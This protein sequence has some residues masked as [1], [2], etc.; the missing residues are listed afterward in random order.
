MI[1]INFL[2]YDLLMKVVIIVCTYNE[3]ENTQNMLPVLDKVIK[4]I[5]AHQVQ[6]LYVDDSS[7]DNTA[8]VIKKGMSEYP[9]LRLLDG[10]KKQG[11]GMAYS[12]GMQYAMKEMA[13]DYLLEF[14]ADFQHPPQDIPRLIAE[15]DRGFDYIVGSRYIPGGSVPK[16]WSADRKMIS[17]FGNLTAR[18]LLIMPKIHDITGGFKLS[19]VKGFMDKF[20]FNKLLSRQFAYKI[21]LFAYMVNAGARVKEVPF[22]FASRTAGDSKIL[23]NEMKETLRVIFKYQ[24]Q[25]PKILRFLKFGIVGGTGLFIQTTFFEIF[26]VFSHTL[27]PSV[28]TT[29]G[30]EMAIISN[31]IL[32]NMWTFNEYKVTGI[33]MI[34]KFVQ[35]NLTSLIALTIQFV[36]L[37][38]GESVSKGNPFVIQLFYFGAIFLVLITNYYIYNKFIWKTKTKAN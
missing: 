3:K 31:F 29:I 16:E 25:N 7:P 24:L 11:L 35:F 17:F 8:D 9:W 32:N 4:S 22:N 10:G 23:K 14:D 28:A 37:K 19:R 21:H 5:T 13:A 20:D 12:R 18:I 27:S 2:S 38:I 36:I 6:V 30:G 26:S 34:E 1:F 15:I 33:K